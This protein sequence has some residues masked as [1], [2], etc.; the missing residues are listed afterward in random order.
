[1]STEKFEFQGE[2]ASLHY[3]AI[4]R[5]SD[6]KVF[7]WLD[8]T[9]KVFA[10]ATNKT[11]EATD[12]LVIGGSSEEYFWIDVDLA[13]LNNT[14]TPEEFVLSWFTD[15]GATTCVSLPSV[16]TV[17]SGEISTPD[18]QIGDVHDILTAAIAELT[19]DPGA[20]PTLPEAVM[21][22]Y[23]EARNNFEIHKSPS[24]R[25]VHNNAGTVILQSTLDDNGDR[26]Q[27][28]KLTVP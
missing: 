8:D 6:G 11:V 28:G 27:R 22:L 7:D 4:F 13:T 9:F 26:F 16:F 19:G 23:M 12:S 24:L 20:T 18:S 10:S 15:S 25:K 14:S 1:M 2:A 3:V 5:V 21:L 17:A